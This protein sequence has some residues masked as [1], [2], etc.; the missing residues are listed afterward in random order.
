MFSLLMVALV[1]NY[2][3]AFPPAGSGLLGLVLA[4]ALLKEEPLPEACVDLAAMYRLFLV[5]KLDFLLEA[6]VFVIL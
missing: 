5:W 1:L 6:V 2:D 3:P 4:F